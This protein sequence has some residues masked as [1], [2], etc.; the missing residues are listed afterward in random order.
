MM[1]LTWLL[2]SAAES[3]SDCCM[4]S[5]PESSKGKIYKGRPKGLDV[6]D[7]P[8]RRKSAA[9]PYCTPG[10]AKCRPITVKILPVKGRKLGDSSE[11]IQLEIQDNDDDVW[12][13][14]DF[15]SFL[16]G[17]SRNYDEEARVPKKHILSPSEVS[18]NPTLFIDLEHMCSFDF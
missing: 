4:Q 15:W 18:F 7:A 1:K 3:S 14:G 10:D 2:M 17:P 6:L 16:G 9:C 12:L 5:N 8:R 11:T 13:P